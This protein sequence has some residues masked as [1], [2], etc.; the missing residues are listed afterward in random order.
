MNSSTTAQ[1]LKLLQD[2]PLDV[3]LEL[4]SF[5]PVPDALSLVS[6]SQR[7]HI[8]RSNHSF[9][10]VL[11]QTLRHSSIP[12]ACPSFVDWTQNL[13]TLALRTLQRQQILSS[14]NPR[15]VRVSKYLGY[16]RDIESISPISGTN[17][18]LTCD[19]TD[20]RAKC[21]D[22]T[23]GTVL[24]EIFIGRNI[25]A[26]STLSAEKGR[27]LV[28][29]LVAETTHEF[30]A[31]SVVVLR[32]DYDVL[33]HNSPSLSYSYSNVQLSVLHRSSLDATFPAMYPSCAINDQG[34]IVI[35]KMATS[36]HLIAINVNTDVK[37]V[38]ETDLT[39]LELDSIDLSFSEKDLIITASNSRSSWMYRC[40]KDNLPY[41]DSD[42]TG[43]RQEL[44]LLSSSTD[45]PSPTTTL[46]YERCGFYAS[47]IQTTNHSTTSLKNRLATT[48]YYVTQC[49]R[50]RYTECCF[51]DFDLAQID[52]VIHTQAAHQCRLPGLQF[53]E[54]PCSG[55]E[56]GAWG[57]FICDVDLDVDGVFADHDFEV[58]VGVD[59]TAANVA[60]NT[61][62]ARTAHL[63]IDSENSKPE[64]FLVH[65]DASTRTSSVHRPVLPESFPNFCESRL[66]P[67][68]Y[69][70]VNDIKSIE[71]DERLGILYIMMEG[72]EGGVLCGIEFL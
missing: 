1:R 68:P 60:R 22:L 20:G 10:H 5:L 32:L 43:S 29:L 71:F 50:E 37:Y 15:P 24:S 7:L 69:S 33:I 53:F 8:L 57:V 34:L 46:S 67:P 23:K 42:V 16:T 40:S 2:L 65:Y 36:I 51:W 38:I 61:G 41:S 66:V 6:T 45:M 12:L 31:T 48:A 64:I 39:E 30:V 58:D 70:W 62:F 3:L 56:S 11:V 19:S 54:V 25:L 14:P 59:L 27:F 17:L 18:Y 72:L 9:W 63:P 21:W 4:I 55:S 35:T 28:C 52:G 44:K 26:K 49:G 13:Q 47:G